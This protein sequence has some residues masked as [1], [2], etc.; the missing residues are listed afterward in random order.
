M[1]RHFNVEMLHKSLSQSSLW[2]QSTKSVCRQ[3]KDKIHGLLLLDTN[4]KLIGIA[5]KKK[6]KEYEE[7]MHFSTKQFAV[8]SSQSSIFHCLLV[9][10]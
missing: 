1:F 6:K 5:K 7:N 3:I 9:F 8:T 10:I 2:D 4:C